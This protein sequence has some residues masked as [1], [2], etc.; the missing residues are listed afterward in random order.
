MAVP[1]Q[2]FIQARPPAALK[3]R[4]IGAMNLFTWGGIMLSTLF[5]YLCNLALARTGYP[6]SWVLAALAP[7]LVGVSL[8]FW[9]T[10]GPPPE[11]K[12]KA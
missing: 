11:P 1:L 8:A 3:G 7:I 9:P 2:V 4:I 12:P 5:Y 6:P 10:V